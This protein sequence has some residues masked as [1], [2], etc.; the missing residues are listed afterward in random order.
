MMLLSRIIRIAG[1]AIILLIAVFA[2]YVATRQNLRFDR[3]FPEVLARTDSSAIER[4]RYLVRH[5]ADCGA[6]HGDPKLRGSAPL[7]QIPLSGGVEWNIPPG[8]FRSPNITADVE[9]GIGGVA[10]A[11]IARALRYG[12][13]ADGRS[14]LPFMEMQGLADDDLVAIVSYLR[15]QPAVSNPVPGHSYTLLGRVIRATVLANP[16]GPAETP[17]AVAPRAVGIETG[18]YLAGSVANCWACHTE[19]D[20]NT[21]KLLG[22]RYGGARSML[23]GGG[24][25]TLWAPPNLTPGP[26]TGRLMQLGL[27]E[28]TFI[29]R[30]RAGELLPGSPMPWKVFRG[31]SDD[32]LRSI[33]RFLMSLP[34]VENDVGP[35]VRV[36][37][38]P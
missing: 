4:G 23:G 3:P 21:G 30:M 33:H 5:V 29:E 19:R 26:K 1:V 38:R 27:T 16:V 12:V 17:P 8:V 18:R 15:S 10:D 36:G 28:D 32:D 6:C 25:D 13:A 22:P 31:M 20:P 2:A 34:P 14:L 9:T 11:A 37:P 7:D 24:S 35:A